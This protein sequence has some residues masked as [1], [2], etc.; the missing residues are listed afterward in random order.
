MK[1]TSTTLI[2]IGDELLYGQTL[3]TNSHWLA[4]KL[5][6][7]AFKVDEILTIPDNR[8]TLLQTLE[9]AFAKYSLIIMTGG[10]GPTKDDLTKKTLVE[11]F[12][13]SL[14][15]DKNVYQHLENIFK[16]KGRNLNNLNREQAYQPKNCTVLPNQI[17]TASGMYFERDGKILIALP[18]VPNEMKNIFE[19]EVAP[20][21]KTHFTLPHL[22]HKFFK[23]IGIPESALAKRLE[24]FEESL[25][26]SVKLAYLPKV[27]EIDLRLTFN[28]TSAQAIE[29]L[30]ENLE[31]QL[32]QTVGE[33]IFAVQ[34]TSVAEYIADYL[35]ARKITV[36]IAE[37][38]T[39]GYIAH[40]FTSIAGSSAYFKGGI[41][42]YSNSIKSNLLGVP[43]PLLENKGAV[44]AEVVRSMAEQTC[45]KF[46]SD[47]ALATSG[48]M[49]PGG[50]SVAK[51]VGTVWVA[52]ADRS[53]NVTATCLHYHYGQRVK[54]IRATYSQTMKLFKHFI[55]S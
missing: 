52:F 46:D 10:L 45:Q 43:P 54:N 29:E 41:V 7:L 47:Y 15:F 33:H 50:G 53:G 32:Y 26:A 17:G 39:G 19:H 30:Y 37:S 42:A 22:N 34:Q 40:Q 18:G 25:P 8:T 5:S 44:S 3:N 11:Y 12:K 38:C 13:T 49:G 23:F 2:S 14:Y 51:P 1:Q 48:V 9:A 35:K 4:Q 55:E 6:H 31:N 20:R 36:A 27:N 28:S 24:K 21:L 16:L